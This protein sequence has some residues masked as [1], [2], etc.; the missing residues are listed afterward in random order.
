MNWLATT[1]TVSPFIGLFGTVIG[2]I[3]AFGALGQAGSA[4]LRAVAPGIADALIALPPYRPLPAAESNSQRDRKELQIVTLE[5]DVV[6]AAFDKQAGATRLDIET[7]TKVDTS[8][9]RRTLGCIVASGLGVV[10][11][12]STD[13]VGLKP[14]GR[15]RLEPV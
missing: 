3:K 12:D 10:H 1:A 2:I 9:R 13:D 4:S 6:P 8:L 11:P 5:E 14:S 15:R 7:G